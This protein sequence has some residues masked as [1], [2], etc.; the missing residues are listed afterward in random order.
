[1][2][3]I[4]ITLLVAVLA[5]IWTG[6]ADGTGMGLG[7]H[8]S[9]VHN[10]STDE[11]TGMLGAH[12]RLRGALLGLEGAIDYR[13]DELGGGVELKTWPVS[14]SLLL[15]PLTPVYALAGLGWY[16]STLDFPA[17]SEYDN[18]TQTELGYHFG[19]GLEVPLAPSLKLTGDIRW[20]FVD[21]EFDDIPSSIG[22]V[23]ADSYSLNA[24]FL[25]Y[26]R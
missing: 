9:R 20:L 22:K 14:A 17:D 7:A 11:N 15:Y 16:N 13:N 24:G 3:R 21:Y 26:L 25:L 4:R 6:Q 1:M 2:A 10:N 12:V 19:A 18:K 5:V 23:D 8:Y